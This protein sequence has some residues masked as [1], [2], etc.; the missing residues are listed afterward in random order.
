[1]GIAYADIR[2][3]NPSVDDSEIEVKALADT[4]AVMMC[5]PEEVADQLGLEPNGKMREVSVADGRIV[6]APYVGPVEVWFARDNRLL[7]DGTI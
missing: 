1:M 3:S 6:K 2:L 7:F 5:I 4:G